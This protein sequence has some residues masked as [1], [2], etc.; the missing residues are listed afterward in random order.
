MVAAHPANGNRCCGVCRHPFDNCESIEVDLVHYNTHGLGVYQC[1][2]C[3]FGHFDMHAMKEH[4]SDCHSNKL[5]YLAKRAVDEPDPDDKLNVYR[6]REDDNLDVIQHLP[7]S[8]LQINFMD[9]SLSE[10]TYNAGDVPSSSEIPRPAYV[11][12]FSFM[13]KLDAIMTSMERIERIYGF[14][15]L[16]PALEMESRKPMD[17]D[18]NIDDNDSEQQHLNSYAP[19]EL[20]SYT[21]NSSGAAYSLGEAQHEASI[22]QEID[23]AARSIVSGTGIDHIQLFRCT[24]CPELTLNA[25]N[26]TE[27]VIG[28]SDTL[29]YA[30]H[31]CGR[32]MVCVNRLKT[33]IVDVHGVHR[34]F[35]YCC[36]ETTISES[37]MDQHYERTHLNQR[38]RYFPLNPNERDKE[39]DFFV[40]CPLDIETINDYGVKLVK[41]YNDQLMSSKKI[42][43][44]DEIHLLPVQPIF[45]DEVQ[46]KHCPYKAKIRTNMLRHLT[47]NNCTEQSEYGKMDPVN[48][49]PCLSSAEKH[50]DKMKNLAASSNNNDIV[51]PSCQFVSDAMR[52]KCGGALCQF[53]A[54]TGNMLRQHIDISHSLDRQY[55]C[56]HCKVNLMSAKP[57]LNGQMIVDHLKFHEAM[58]YKCSACKF[59]HYT[60]R[61]VEN[62]VADIHRNAGERVITVIRDD[63][64]K[65]PTTHSAGK[66]V[67]FK[68][69]CNICSK[70]N[71]DTRPLI[72][73]HLV[74]CHRINFQF[75]CS[76][77][78]YQTDGK[79][80][81]KEHLSV[82]HKKLGNDTFKTHF[83][84]IESDADNTPIWRRDDTTKV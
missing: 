8:E 50:A 62:H 65:E 13:Q 33:H 9:P 24:N 29:W 23:N 70:A 28:H 31:H 22:Q 40:A 79:A 52:Y 6:L 49:V 71:F 3:V 18:A 78:P 80:T 37:D 59:V 56:P 17:K 41:R 61:S 38:T 16:E 53:R 74:Q 43:G 35:C 45:K 7:F 19:D 5:P 21:W 63:K 66:A 36:D 77:C 84:K 60:K 55:N 82:M 25:Q 54:L 26:F 15:V 20:L 44:P 48:P 32:R 10:Y 39:S 73:A 58:L 51:D 69:R 4:L 14:E 83:D 11:D 47:R 42:F 64:P 34:F 57:L 2:F 46:C 27:H 67:T 68:W 72:K 81:I 1:L 76:M 75:Q 12:K 30:C